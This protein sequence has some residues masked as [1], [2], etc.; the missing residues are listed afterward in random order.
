MNFRYELD[1]R[2]DAAFGGSRFA[3]AQRG[4]FAARR[5][6]QFLEQSALGTIVGEFQN[7]VGQL[8]ALPADLV[9][10]GINAAGLQKYSPEESEGSQNSGKYRIE[11]TALPS[12]NFAYK[13]F[14]GAPVF[15]TI[16]VTSPF[17][18]LFPHDPLVD[19]AFEKHF[20]ETPLHFGQEV[21][22]LVGEKPAR[23]SIRGILWDNTQNYPTA[24]KQELLRV[25]R[26]N[27][28]LDVNSI[29]FLSSRIPQ[30]Y[31]KNIA[32]AATEGCYDTIQYEIEARAYYPQ[33]LKLTRS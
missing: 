31:I 9:A 20:V 8:K 18:Y 13:T 7:G 19:V 11:E 2:L 12:S 30:I 28:V 5:T 3:K 33:N 27:A 14:T 10:D 17:E 32:F 1:K 29:V 25:F 22:E 26:T 16:Q 15:D 6:T 24:Q 4:G 23:I 21:V